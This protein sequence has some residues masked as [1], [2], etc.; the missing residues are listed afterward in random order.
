MPAMLGPQPSPAAAALGG[1]L[2]ASIPLAKRPVSA[3]PAERGCNASEGRAYLLA[4]AARSNDGK[5]RARLQ[6]MRLKVLTR[7]QPPLQPGRTV[8]LSSACRRVWKGTHDARSICSGAKALRFRLRQCAI[9]LACKATE[10]REIYRTSTC[11]LRRG[12]SSRNIVGDAAVRQRRLKHCY[13]RIQLGRTSLM[14]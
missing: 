8:D 7:S 12:I 10:S 14:E 13:M 3:W 4:Q 11:G 2:A 9:P 1:P 5:L 6:Q